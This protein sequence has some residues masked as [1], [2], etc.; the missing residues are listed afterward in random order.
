MRF[1]LIV[2]AGALAIAGCLSH[3]SAPAIPG[4][5]S[6]SPPAF[7][8][9]APVLVDKNGGAGEPSLWVDPKD[10][11]VYVSGPLGSAHYRADALW[12][13]KDH[14]VTFTRVD[15]TTPTGMPGGPDYPFG[16]GDS[17]VTTGGDGTLYLAGQW[18][19]R[20]YV[21]DTPL[22]PITGPAPGD[23]QPVCESVSVSKDHGATWTTNPFGCVV[24]G[25]V[26]RQ[27]LDT[28]GASTVYMAFN[29]GTTGLTVTKSTDSG[30]TW[31]SWT[32]VVETNGVNGEFSARGD[33]VAD[34]KTDGLVY[35][36]HAT[37]QGPAI[38]VS[39]D[40][41]KTFTLKPVYKTTAD[42]S[43]IFNIVAIDRE[44]NLYQVWSEDKK[45]DGLVIFMATSSDHGNT[46]T[47]PV[48]VSP[49]KHTAIFPWIVA[50]D[51][52][53]V[54]VA[55]YETDKVGDPNT[56]AN[57]T[58]WNAYTAISTN[59]LAGD[60]TRF[61]VTKMSDAPVHDGKLCTGG[62]SCDSNYRRLLD[63][64]EIAVSPDGKLNAVYTDDTRG[65]SQP[66]LNHFAVESA[67][68]PLFA[69]P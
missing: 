13:S 60:A 11:T 29:D 10:A 44:G 25:E 49:L 56:M 6:P 1:A 8:M 43:T 67:G 46:W 53:R 20:A 15:P 14:G 35:V 3:P 27:W 52:G 22:A 12:M 64:F 65:L 41:A 68:P 38:A 39:T 66:V 5:P 62:S 57:G 54:A 28:F 18:G 17:D 9:G 59:A 31:T 61:D 19:A 24:P 37:S 45:E 51:A 50:G 4:L 48:A 47:L 63:F 36:A 32:P 42:V 7:S 40:G 34:K 21:G 69:S 16:G 30:A 23:P 33:L 55:W 2:L 58:L 26:D